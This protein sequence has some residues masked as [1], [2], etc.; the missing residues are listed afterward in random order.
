MITKNYKYDRP[1]QQ[2][3]IKFVREADNLHLSY[4]KLQIRE[5]CKEIFTIERRCALWQERNHQNIQN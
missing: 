3:M 2:R 5:V 4:G 1:N